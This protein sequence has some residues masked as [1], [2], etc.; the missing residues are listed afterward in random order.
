M[1]KVKFEEYISIR[2]FAC[3][4][5]REKMIKK[6]HEWDATKPTPRDSIEFD[7]ALKFAKTKNQV[8]PS[9]ERNYPDSPEYHPTTP[10]YCPSSPSY[11]PMEN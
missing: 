6:V 4:D 8:P 3:E 7:K 5:C 2:L 9:P 1:D 10:D 11:G